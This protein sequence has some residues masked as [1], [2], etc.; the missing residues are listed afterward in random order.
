MY[1]CMLSH[2]SHAWLFVTLWIV[3]CQAILSKGFSRQEYLSG[4]PLPPLGDPP[5][6][7]IEPSSLASP[8]LGG[9]FFTISTTWEAIGI[10]RTFQLSLLGISGWGIDLDYYDVE[11]FAL[12]TNWE[13]AVIFVTGPKYCISDSFVDYEDYSISPKG[14][15]PTVVD[16]MVFWIIF[17]FPA[18]FSSLIHKMLMFTL[19]ISCLTTSNLS[20]LW[21]DIPGSYTVL[22]FTVWDFTF[23]TRHPQ[24]GVVSALAQP[25]HSFW[26][27]FSTLLQ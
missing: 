10:H 21:P 4:L 7:G 15:L 13:N 1:A 26:S 25:L 5:E 20:W 18:H 27:Y 16:I 9:G 2:F 22:L 17:A 8:A 3:A 6:P 14:F 19:A 12:Q 24:L 23:T 11:W